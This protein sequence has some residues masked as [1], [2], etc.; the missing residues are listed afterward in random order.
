MTRASKEIVHLCRAVTPGDLDGRTVCNGWACTFSD[1]PL[2]R[3]K[4][5][6]ATKF[7]VYR[8]TSGFLYSYNLEHVTCEECKK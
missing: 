5:K 3:W 2:R 1:K 7:F 6:G 8:A 4:D